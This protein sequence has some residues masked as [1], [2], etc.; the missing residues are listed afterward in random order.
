MIYYGRQ[1]VDKNDINAVI[2][3]LKSDYLTQGPLV[4][5]FE[6]KLKKKLNA[7]YCT[8]V[9]NGTAALHLTALA[10]G[11]KTGDVILTTPITFVAS[12][13][14][15]LYTGAK[16]VFVDIEEDY[17]N[18]DIKK[19]E[20][21][22]NQYKNKVKAIIAT[23]FAGHPCDWKSINK[24][25]ADKN[26]VLVNDN[27]HAFGASI[28]NNYCYQLKYADIVTQ[29][30]H[31]VK[32]ITTG[33]GGAILTN[34]KRLDN[35]FKILRTHGIKK[36]FAKKTWHYDMKVLGFNYRLS[37]MQCALGISQ[38][39]KLNIFLEKRKKIAKLYDN[40]FS[41]IKFIT[42]PKVKKFY[43]HAYH[44][45]PLKINFRKFRITK[46]SFFSQLRKRNISL[47]VHYRPI[48][49]H[50]FYKKKIKQ[51]H[52]PVAERFYKD[53]ISLPIYYLLKIKDAEK[54]VRIIKSVLNVKKK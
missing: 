46:E 26:I 45:Y 47:K 52:L 17:Y 18:I 6:E 35:T 1:F 53:E 21:K 24:I 7:K 4:E 49:L 43:S 13:N 38:L 48:Y 33:E 39:K 25:V 31:P 41:N 12:S 10:L 22:I 28:D 11:W 36:N 29:S 50:S 34:N 2:K 23:D 8:V 32:Q 3:V 51:S 30:F 16:P 5:K 37:D 20:K 44:L 40:L 19:L 15:I 14:C 27:C 42:T 9:S 54:V